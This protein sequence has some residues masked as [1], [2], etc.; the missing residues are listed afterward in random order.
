MA[1]L[2]TQERQATPFE[3]EKSIKTSRP[4]YSLILR[5]LVLQVTCFDSPFWDKELNK[6]SALPLEIRKVSARMW[7]DFKGVN[8]L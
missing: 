8:L 5:R 3:W 2:V 1:P 6:Y 7:L 4:G